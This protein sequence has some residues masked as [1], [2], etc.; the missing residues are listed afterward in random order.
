M[1]VKDNWQEKE[2]KKNEKQYQQVPRL[3]Q[4]AHILSPLDSVVWTWTLRVSI[5]GFDTANDNRSRELRFPSQ[6]ARIR[7]QRRF[8]LRS[9]SDK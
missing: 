3:K 9:E 1:D 4:I 2:G 8:F 5:L 7:E 6:E